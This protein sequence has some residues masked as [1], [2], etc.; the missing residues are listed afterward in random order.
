MCAAGDRLPWPAVRSRVQPALAQADVALAAD[1]DMVEE[2][3][4]EQVPGP[5]GLPGEP[6]VLR[7]RRWIARGVVVH[8]DD[9][10]RAAGDRLPEAVRQADRRGVQPALVDELRA[11][12]M[13]LRI[14]QDDAQLLLR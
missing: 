2:L 6:H 14:E 12:D 7:R 9:R 8:Q 10:R 1:D 11:D 4:A 13:V 3:H 5:A